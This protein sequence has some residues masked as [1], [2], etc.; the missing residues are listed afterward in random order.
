MAWKREKDPFI[1]EPGTERG[2]IQKSEMRLRNM[3]EAERKSME[4]CMKSILPH[5]YGGQLRILHYL[6][7]FFK[8]ADLKP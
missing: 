1:V 5:R 8:E 6:F 2:G 7:D 4:V 3:A